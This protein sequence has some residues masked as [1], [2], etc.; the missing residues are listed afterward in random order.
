MYDFLIGLSFDEAIAE[1]EARGI[2]YDFCSYTIEEARRYDD[3]VVGDS[4][5]GDHCWTA[6]F[7]EIAP[8]VRVIKSFLEPV[9]WRD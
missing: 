1:L 4:Y 2:E 8:R 9:P 7:E 5:Y 6:E 3:L